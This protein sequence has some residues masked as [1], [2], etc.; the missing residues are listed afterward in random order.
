VSLGTAIQAGSTFTAAGSLNTISVADTRT[1]GTAV[2]GWSISGQVSDFTS[3]ANSFSAGYLGWTPSVSNAG[4]G[5]SA[6]A[7]VT[8]TATAGT[9][10]GTSAT[11]ASSTAAASADIDAALAL[12]I[13]TTTAAGDY[14]AT[15]T[16]TAL[17]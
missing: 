17:G 14:S 11:L 2:Y 4:T 16:V 5:V 12:V 9:G 3:A 6:G 13:P 7:A 1:G 15:L 8:S 10:L